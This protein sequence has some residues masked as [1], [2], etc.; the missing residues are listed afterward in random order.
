MFYGKFIDIIELYKMGPKKNLFK[1]IYI[2]EHIGAV[3]FM[4]PLQ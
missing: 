3:V 2:H 4:G 1:Y